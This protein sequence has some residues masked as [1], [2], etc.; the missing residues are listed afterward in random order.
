MY[1]KCISILTYNVDVRILNSVCY[2]LLAKNYNYIYV[3]RIS[4]PISIDINIKYLHMILCF[5]MLRDDY[6]YFKVSS[7]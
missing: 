4:T 5:I 7:S 2:N 1:W 6:N 3:F